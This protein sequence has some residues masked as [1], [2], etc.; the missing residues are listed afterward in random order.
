MT[1]VPHC[2]GNCEGK[3]NGALE[4][5]Y[6]KDCMARSITPNSA[7]VANLQQLAPCFASLS[8]VSFRN[9]FLGDRGAEVVL[10]LF[11]YSQQVRLLNLSGVGLRSHTLRTLCVCLAKH[12]LH[13]VDVSENRLGPAAFEPLFAFL[14]LHPTTYEM[15]VYKTGITAHDAMVLQCQMVHNR[16]L[17]EGGAACADAQLHELYS[18]YERIPDSVDPHSAIATTDLLALADTTGRRRAQPVGAPARAVR[19]SRVSVVLRRWVVCRQKVH[20][21]TEDQPFDLLEAF[22]SLEDFGQGCGSDFGSLD[23]DAMIH[24]ADD[25]IDSNDESAASREDIPEAW[26][27]QVAQLQRRVADLEAENDDLQCRVEATKIAEA[28]SRA[29]DSLVDMGPMMQYLGAMRKQAEVIASSHEEALRY[30]QATAHTM[31]LPE[32]LASA[33]QQLRDAEARAAAAAAEAKAATA[34]A[35]DLESRLAIAEEMV[36]QTQNKLQEADDRA[37]TLSSQTADA[38]G[39]A[40]VEEGRAAFAERRLREVEVLWRDAEEGHRNAEQRC[41]EALSRL[42][43]SERAAQQRATVAAA[44]EAAAAKMSAKVEEAWDKVLAAERAQA[45]SATLR[46]AAEQSRLELQSQLEELQKQLAQEQEAGAAIRARSEAVIRTTVSD[47]LELERLRASE[48]QHAAIL[49]AADREAQFLREQLSIAEAV[50]QVQEDAREQAFADTRVLVEA[51]S[52]EL[53]PPQS[54]L[55]GSG[56]ISGQN[57]WMLPAEDGRAAVIAAVDR[58]VRSLDAEALSAIEAEAADL[59]ARLRRIREA[60]GVEDVEQDCVDPSDA[61]LALCRELAVFSSDVAAFEQALGLP[62]MEPAAGTGDRALAIETSLGGQLAE[63]QARADAAE[64]ERHAEAQQA[65]RMA[66]LLREA[67][68]ALRQQ[69][70]AVA[71]LRSGSHKEN[72]HSPGPDGGEDRGAGVWD[73]CSSDAADRPDGIVAE[74]TALPALPLGQMSVLA[75]ESEA[76]AHAKLPSQPLDGDRGDSKWAAQLEV[77]RGELAESTG[78]CA[79]LE[80]LLRE[81]NAE[82]LSFVRADH[83]ALEGLR[84]GDNTNSSTRPC[85]S[86]RA[87]YG[88]SRRWL[89]PALDGPPP[90][91]GRPRSR[92]S[93]AKRGR[94]SVTHEKGGRVGQLAAHLVQLLGDEWPPGDDGFRHT[95]AMSEWDWKQEAAGYGNRWSD[96][97]TREPTPDYSPLRQVVAAAEADEAIGGWMGST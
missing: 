8:A 65:A 18:Q 57:G 87:D 88:H 13:A 3:H 46:A 68:E 32:E 21:R 64:R 23:G 4:T 24:D 90:P 14:A 96:G 94:H 52:Q 55:D 9:Y 79:E 72:V 7:V 44:S 2:D 20:A 54:V 34:R 86:A 83:G 19:D 36:A 31:R 37:A 70:G 12:P 38:R 1:F 5:K 69:R 95:S 93:V 17:S 77:L 33:E 75:A 28:R 71:A 25:D 15:C 47:Q 82:R 84:R 85:L 92:P 39:R 50:A 45:S 74:I 89:E 73:P 66:V 42:Q 61:R 58:L 40:A 26:S 48:A 35:S 56:L 97:A 41:V 27:S 10:Q 78:R 49:S 60:C 67:E 6:R 53:V 62:E 29:L 81:R 80:R 76:I 51:A 11:A 22:G 30:Q 16:Q 59:R 63:A 91:V 43:G